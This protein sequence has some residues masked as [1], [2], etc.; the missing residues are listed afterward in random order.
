MVK[1]QEIIEPE[2]PGGKRGRLPGTRIRKTTDLFFPTSVAWRGTEL[3]DERQDER[4]I[5]G[6]TILG[7]PDVRG[8][9]LPL[10]TAGFHPTRFPMGASQSN[11]IPGNIISVPC[12]KRWFQQIFLPRNFFC[13]IS[14]AEGTE[15]FGGKSRLAFPGL[16]ENRIAGE[17]GDSPKFRMKKGFI[18][19]PIELRDSTT[20]R[21]FVLEG[22]LFQC[23]QPPALESLKT[24]LEWSLEAAVEGIPL[25]PIGVI[26]DLGHLA[27]GKDPSLSEPPTTPETAAAARELFPLPAILI[28]QYEDF[29]LGKLDTDRSFDRAVDA[30]CRYSDRRDRA[31]ALAFFFRQLGQRAGSRGVLLSPAVIRNLARLDPEEILENAETNLIENGPLGLDD[32]A[33]ESLEKSNEDQPTLLEFLYRDLVKQVRGMGDVLGV[34]DI[35]ELEHGT[36]IAGFGQRVALRQ[37]LKAVAEFE[38]ALPSQPVRPIPRRQQ[39]VTQIVDED[40]YPVGGFSSISNRGSIESLLHSQLA[41]MEPGDRPDLFDIKFLRD[42]LLYYSRDENQFLRRRRNFLFALFPDLA[43]SRIKDPSLPWQRIV[44]LMG[45]LVEAVKKLTDWL[46]EDALGFEFV[47]LDPPEPRAGKSD[48]LAE[49]RE[50]FEMLFREQI[51]NHTVQLSEAVSWN[52]FVE[53]CE[54][55]ARRGLCQATLVSTG[56][57]HSIEIENALITQLQLDAPVPKIAIDNATTEAL[58]AETPW[59]GWRASLERLLAAWVAG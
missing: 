36:A 35:F 30:L 6:G 47:F 32:V 40:T 56:G 37:V 49:E 22:L 58:E 42:E 33:P 31:K 13:L 17:T 10:P 39:V 34:E 45:L 46:G 20:A 11:Q 25:P 29:V 51:A 21:R 7:S 3:R 5:E 23:V 41:Y 54:H 12:V 48:N 26:A 4:E 43:G 8:W 9:R 50:L 24:V 44:L 53:K 15:R 52:E 55:A 27:F 14:S 1:L 57:D 19:N 28:R 59:D 38:A 2:I 16:L 18:P